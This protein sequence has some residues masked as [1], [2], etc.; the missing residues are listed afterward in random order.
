[1][2]VELCTATILLVGAGLLSKSLYQL[3]HTET[4]MQPDHLATLGLLPPSKYSKEDQKL[5]LANRIIADVSRLPGVQSVAVAHGLPI[6]NIAGGSTTFE[7]LDRDKNRKQNN[8]ANGREVSAKYFTTIGARLIQGRWFDETDNTSH[9]RVAIV[10]HAFAS[11]YFAGQYAVGKRF[12]FDA[13]QP[14][15]EIVGVVNDLREGPLDG[16]VQPTIYT[17]FAQGGESNFSVVARTEQAPQNLLAT[18]EKTVHQVDPDVLTTSAETMEDRI[19][20]L[21]SIYLHRSSAWLSGG[22]AAVALLLSV[23]GLYGVIAFSVSQRTREIGV[24][25]AL[26]A[27]RDSVYRLILGQGTRLIVTGI[28]FGLLCALGAGIL[29]GKFLFQTRPW[30]GLTFV[31]VAILLAISALAA[32]LIPAHRAATVEPTTALRSE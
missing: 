15:I 18:L 17:P 3:M 22:F 14:P 32:C 12:R 10:N 6:S 20:K 16:D 27:P 30:D 24:R 11:K 8:E 31:S 26:G 13:S 29:M 9:P 1:V 23:I 28:A 4:G 19:Q 5:A 7:I 2:V 21:Q 25:I